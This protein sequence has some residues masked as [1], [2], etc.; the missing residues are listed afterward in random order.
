MYYFNKPFS[1]QWEHRVFITLNNL[2]KHCFNPVH[3]AMLT[4][5]V[6]FNSTDFKQ[7]AIINDA[8]TIKLLTKYERKNAMRQKVNWHQR[9]EEYDKQMFIYH[10]AQRKKVQL[11]CINNG[12]KSIRALFRTLPNIFFFEKKIYHRSWQRRK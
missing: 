5:F 9:I 3:P 2:K 7:I 4:N 6:T 10:L 8:W 11:Y 1:Q 12:K